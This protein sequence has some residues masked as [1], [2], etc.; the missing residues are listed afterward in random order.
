MSPLA[1][2]FAL[3]EL[4]ADDFALTHR[5]HSRSTRLAR[6]HLHR[7]VPRQTLALVG[8][9]S[10]LG[11]EFREL[12]DSSELPLD[13]K[14][15]ASDEDA[16]TNIIAAGHDEPLVMSSLARGEAV[17]AKLLV[18]AGSREANLTAYEQVRSTKPA[19]VVI[20]LSGALE[21]Q[22]SARLRAPIDR[23]SVV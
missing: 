11:K 17:T 2:S 4:S 1:F 12:V 10:L 18:L 20:D 22:P 6:T 8:G 9:D 16:D 23:K 5:V 13:L 21:Q 3:V 19:P 7:V 15:I 14:L